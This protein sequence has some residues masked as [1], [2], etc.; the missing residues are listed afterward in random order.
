MGK[1]LYVL[2]FEY[3]MIVFICTLRL[4]T[5]IVNCK[6]L[7]L[8]YPGTIIFHLFILGKGAVFLFAC[9]TILPTLS[10]PFF[11]LPA[12]FFILPYY[13]KILRNCKLK[14]PILLQLE[15]EINICQL[16]N[17]LK[18]MFVLLLVGNNLT[19][20]IKFPIFIYNHNSPTQCIFN[21]IQ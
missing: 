13:K 5:V 21:Y 6:G 20:K 3:Q 15:S 8:P 16:P 17:F 19:I 4:T 9:N 1:D 11:L 2:Y 18:I 10:F 7:P 12:N 14:V